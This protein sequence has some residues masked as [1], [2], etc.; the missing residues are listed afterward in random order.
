MVMTSHGISRALVALLATACGISVASLYYAQPLLHT[1]AGG[2]GTSSGIAGLIVTSSQIGYALGLAF[3]VPSGDLLNRRRLVP[4]MLGVSAAGLFASAVAP[5]V[6][7]L[8]ALASV[9]GVGSVAAQLLVPLAASL[10]ADD[11]RGRVTGTV[12]SG[13]LLGILLARTLSGLIAGAAGWR[14]V[15]GSAAGLV[16]LLAVV[17][18]RALP[19]ERPRPAIGYRAVLRSTLS[20]P[21]REPLLR[22]RML[23]GGLCFASFS[24]FWTTVAFLLAGSPFHYGET[25]IGLF[26][27]VGAAGALCASFAGRLADRGRSAVSTGAFA[28]TITASFAVLYAGRHSVVGVIVGVV[29]LDVGVQGL[30]VTNQ[31]LVFRLPSELRSRVNANYMVAY[32]A[33][34]ASGSALAGAIYAS[35]GWAGVCALGAGTGLAATLVWVFDRLRPLDPALTGAVISE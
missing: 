23:L 4:A 32:F 24:I 5:N 26:G 7:T 20:L 13:L 9:V 31:S 28:L 19:P 12:M 14:V 25:V 34:G 29:V 10:A 15:Y 18:L 16:V 22:R 35:D 6:A 17:L 3:V 27:L 21:G 1:I 30:H 33:G 8:I 11:E 2:F